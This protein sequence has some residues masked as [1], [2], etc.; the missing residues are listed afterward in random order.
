[1]QPPIV[2]RTD[3]EIAGIEFDSAP[4]GPASRFACA[5]D[6]EL[7]MNEGAQ[8]VMA[9][10]ILAGNL[11]TTFGSCKVKGPTVVEALAP[12]NVEGWAGYI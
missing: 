8:S 3:T 9:K 11:F 1:M 2:E 7:S 4:R 10:H 12:A 6:L 5:S